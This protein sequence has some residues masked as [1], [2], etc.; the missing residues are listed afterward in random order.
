MEEGE[1]QEVLVRKF[2]SIT[3]EELYMRKGDLRRDE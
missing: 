3:V 1:M 2:D